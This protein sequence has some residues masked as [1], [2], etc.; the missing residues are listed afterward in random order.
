MATDETSRRRHH[1]TRTLRLLAMIHLALAVPLSLWIAVVFA[2]G[3]TYFRPV[4]SAIE[5]GD[6]EPYRVAVRCGIA[7]ADHLF[8]PAAVV[9]ASSAVL[10][11]AVLLGPPSETD[12]PEGPT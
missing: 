4:H 12:R 8:W 2:F 7:L 1:T 10:A 5:D 3:N 9:A 6:D 11:T